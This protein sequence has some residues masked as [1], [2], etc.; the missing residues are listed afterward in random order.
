[1]EGSFL[2]QRLSPLTKTTGF[3]AS[4]LSYPINT[5]A[6]LANVW[7]EIRATGTRQRDVTPTHLT[8]HLT[9]AMMLVR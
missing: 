4:L 5:F 3:E 2:P 9:I 7:D 8:K 1:M 6:L